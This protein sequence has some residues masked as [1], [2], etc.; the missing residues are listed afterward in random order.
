MS[1]YY[2][3][4]KSKLEGSADSK[5]Y[6]SSEEDKQIT[7]LDDEPKKTVPQTVKSALVSFG[8][9][10]VTPFM[11]DPQ[12]KAER[13]KK[14]ARIK[15]MMMR[16]KV[17]QEN[18]TTADNAE[19]D[20]KAQHPKGRFRPE[21]SRLKKPRSA[22]KSALKNGR[23]PV[24]RPGTSKAK[25]EKE[26]LEL[27]DAISEN[28]DDLVEDVDVINGVPPKKE[29]FTDPPRP[30][31]ARRAA[32][33]TRPRGH[34]QPGVP[35]A[36][37]P[38]HGMPP[39]GPT[40]RGG[41]LPPMPDFSRQPTTLHPKPSPF[42]NAGPPLG[43]QPVGGPRHPNPGP[44][45]MRQPPPPLR[46][47]M[48]GAQESPRPAMAA[49][50]GSYVDGMPSNKSPRLSGVHDSRPSMAARSGS[51]V[52]EM[53]SSLPDEG[54]I[55][56]SR[57]AMAARSGSYVG[58]MHSKS[59]RSERRT[60]TGSPLPP[61]PPSRSGSYVGDMSRTPRSMSLTGELPLR[62]VSRSGSISSDDLPMRPVSRSGSFSRD[63]LPMRRPV[64]RSGSISQDHSMR[65][66]IPEDSASPP[67]LSYNA[68]NSLSLDDSK[69]NM[70]L[71]G[72][73]TSPRLSLTADDV[74]KL[75]PTSPAGNRRASVGATFQIGGARSPATHR[76]GS[77]GGAI[78]S[79]RPINE[80]ES[81]NI[82]AG[83]APGLIE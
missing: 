12:V 48:M 55:S 26:Q 11:T 17:A 65:I 21:S 53:P 37:P 14:M 51:Y 50:S 71:I 9:M 22:L 36:L 5:K 82:A 58:V 29:E 67:M 19:N 56:D 78:L 35:G 83:S 3:S 47:P 15:D 32:P 2:C 80:E 73:S 27:Q 70:S 45:G 72:G 28:A 24:K 43:S 7:S 16:N 10:L 34:A 64:S 1:Q 25:K 61:R 57:P 31:T 40:P 69:R 59:P 33:G 30:G 60:S 13:E 20:T 6:S 44:F 66:A 68:R 81:E 52:G 39:G 62:P 41:A 79:P 74:M 76:K 38:L 42:G 54:D 4:K 49:R 18:K 46:P 77:I 8:K 63:E 23:G 75:S